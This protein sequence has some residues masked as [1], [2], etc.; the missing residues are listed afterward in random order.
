L[1]RNLCGDKGCKSLV[2]PPLPISTTLIKVTKFLRKAAGAF[3]PLAEI[4]SIGLAKG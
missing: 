2:V 3:I 4:I 1:K